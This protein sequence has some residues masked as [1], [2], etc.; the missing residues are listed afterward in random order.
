MHL[1][2]VLIKLK[3]SKQ[4]MKQQECVQSAVK[5]IIVAAGINKFLFMPF[6][7]NA[8]WYE[9]AAVWLSNLSTQLLESC[10]T[11]A[12]SSGSNGSHFFRVHCQLTVHPIGVVHPQYRICT[13][14]EATTKVLTLS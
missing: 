4:F 11:D 6:V 12:G 10:K 1:L 7:W 5:F 3:V 14:A 9:N 2:V 8:T 13:S